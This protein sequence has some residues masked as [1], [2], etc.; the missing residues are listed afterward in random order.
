MFS[1][2]GGGTARVCTKEDTGPDG[3]RFVGIGI[4]PDI[5]VQLSVA[6]VRNNVDRALKI[7]ISEL[8]K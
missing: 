8:K 6:D 2:P 1:L 7:A 3:S 5:N 4:L